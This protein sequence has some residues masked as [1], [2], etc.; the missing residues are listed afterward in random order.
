MSNVVHLCRSAYY[1]YYVYLQVSQCVGDGRVGQ[2]LFLPREDNR[3]GQH[4]LTDSALDL[5]GQ[6]RRGLTPPDLVARAR[7]A[8]G[9]EKGDRSDERQKEITAQRIQ[10]R[11]AANV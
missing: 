7:Y 8:A 9:S 6:L 3:S 11:R 2:R 10:S 5:L 4:K 1:C